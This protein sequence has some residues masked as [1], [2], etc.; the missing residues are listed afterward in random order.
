MVMNRDR[1]KTGT[2]PAESTS[3]PSDGQSRGLTWAAL[4]GKWTEFAKAGVAF[5]D[6]SE[7]RRWKASVSPIISLQ[8]VT[9]ALGEIDLI[10]EADE[11]AAALDRAEV[12]IRNEIGRL[13]DVWSTNGL[14]EPLPDQLDELVR[15]A[16]NALQ[17]AHS[18]G[19]EWIVREH[20]LIAPDPTDHA[21]RLI[22]AGATGNF[23]AAKPGTVLFRNEPLAFLHTGEAE[24]SFQ[25]CRP[26]MAARPHQI[27]RQIDDATGKIISDRVVAFEESLPAGMPLLIPVIDAGRLV[28]AFDDEETARWVEM[29]RQALGDEPIPTFWEVDAPAPGD[30]V[31]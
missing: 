25:G 22:D 12:V 20:R 21:R 15:D 3:N 14:K 7:G 8:A 24:L 29:Q 28:A 11:R 17:A 2:R 10:R 13:H 26:R 31:E 16:W 5:P 4:L 23:F 27:Y 30:S 18:G 9:M 1:P 6:D 19:V